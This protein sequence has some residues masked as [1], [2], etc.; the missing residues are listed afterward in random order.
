LDAGGNPTFTA[1]RPLEEGESL[2]IIVEFPKGYVERPDFLLF[3]QVY[4][5]VASFFA[6]LIQ[7]LIRI[8]L[9]LIVIGFFF[10]P[11]IFRNSGRGRGSKGRGGGGAAAGGGGGAGDGGG[12]GGGGDGGAGGGGGG[13]G[14]GGL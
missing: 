2:R 11:Y 4:W 1:T 7:V 3:K 10:L 6:A 9:F 5:A 12:G 8:L 13:D 14:G